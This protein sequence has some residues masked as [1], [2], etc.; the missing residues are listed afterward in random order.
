MERLSLSCLS[1]YL[2]ILTSLLWN[3][4]DVVFKVDEY[5]SALVYTPV[6]SVFHPFSL[7]LIYSSTVFY[8]FLISLF[9]YSLLSNH[10]LQSLF[11]NRHDE[12]SMCSLL[13]LTSSSSWSGSEKERRQK[14][15]AM[16]DLISFKLAE[17]TQHN[18]SYPGD[19]KPRIYSC[20]SRHPPFAT[21]L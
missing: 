16:H 6:L 18:L 9:P 15:V 7:S 14:Q 1:I 5:P 20:T 8:I 2:C 11:L 19:T 12:P 17:I 21:S 10:H 4:L 13:T 3:S